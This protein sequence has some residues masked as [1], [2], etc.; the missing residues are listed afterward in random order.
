MSSFAEPP[1]VVGE[2]RTEL[3]L[4]QGQREALE[5]EA[6]AISAELKSP[7]PNGE[8]PV[9]IKGP[10]VDSDGYPLAGFDLFNVREKRH[11]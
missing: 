6:G 5:M 11:R 8:T 7:G 10:L 9:G 2:R 4:L 1:D 3:M